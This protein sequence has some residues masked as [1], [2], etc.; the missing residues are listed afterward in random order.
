MGHPASFN[1]KYLGIG[2]EQWGKEYPERLEPFIKALRKAH[3]EIMIV[4]SSG[5]NSE[6]KEFDYLWPEMKRLKADLVDEHFYRPESWFLSQGARYDNYDRKGPKVFAGEYACHG[7]GKK[8]NHFHAALLEAAFMT[9][10][11]RNADIVHMATYAPLFAHVEGWQ[12]RPDMI[13]FDNLNSVRTVSYYVQQLYAQN[14]GTNVLPLTMNK[15]PVTG[16]E[17]QNGLFASA[18]YD[19][20]KNELIVKVANTSDKTQ[21]VSLTFE[22]LK[23]Q[24]VLSEGRCITLSSLDQDKDNTLEQPFA[25]TPQETPVTINGHALTTELGPNTFAVYKFTKK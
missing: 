14:K 2:N 25:I 8:W 10:L 6:G 22:G 23:K 17:G 11:E 21:P 24:D 1:L 13:W 5:P 18:V 3:P 7:K 4:G 9:G 19:K 15:K 20:D 16:A 12:W